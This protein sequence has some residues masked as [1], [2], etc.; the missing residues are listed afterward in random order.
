LRLTRLVL[1]R[2]GYRVL[3]AVNGVEALEVWDRHAGAI[4]LVLTDLVMP[5]GMSGRDLVA[6]LRQRDSRVRAIFTSGYSADFAG[7]ELQLLEGQNFIQKPSS[8]RA[9]LD[10]VRRTL[11]R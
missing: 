2:S 5:L 10:M 7:Q 1:S 8:P 4:D 9:L 3:E 6:Q 11:D